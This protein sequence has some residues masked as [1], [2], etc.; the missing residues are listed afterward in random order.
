MRC[1]TQQHPFYGGID[2]HARTMFLC[3]LHRD[4]AMLVHRHRPAGPEPLLKAIAPS[5]EAVVVCV[6]CLF[7]WDWLVDLCARE[8]LPCVLGH[9][10]SMQAIHGGNATHDQ[11]DAQHMAVRR[12]GG[13]LLQASGSP[14]ARRATRA[15]RQRR[16]PLTRTRAAV[17]APIQQTHR[18]DTLPAS[19]QKRASK[20]HRGGGAARCPAPAVPTRVAVDLA[21]RACAD[22][23]R[24][25]GAL[26]S[27]QTA[28]QHDA[29]TVSRLP[30]GPGIGHIVHV[31]WLSER[32]EST[33][34][35]RLQDGVASGRLGT[36]AQA[37]AG[38]R[39]GTPGAQSGHA[40][41]TWAC[42]AAVGLCL[43]THPAGHKSLARVEKTPGQGKAWTVV[44]QTRAR[45][46]SARRR[47]ATVCE[48]PKV[49]NASERG[50]G[51]PHA[52]RDAPGLSLAS[53]ALMLALPRQNTLPEENNVRPNTAEKQVENPRLGSVCLLTTGVL[54][55][56]RPCSWLTRSPPGTTL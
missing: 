41:R 16:G 33:R 19:G 4:G 38:Q 31:V 53:G 7:T 14:A 40:Y 2:V 43:R 56:V 48:R 28:Q 46:V 36:C 54:I 17:R 5:R 18:L 47:R 8:G 45:A 20:A 24:R 34:V 13:R 39:E 26:T 21:L 35:P 9:A 51:E 15:L 50:A 3:I 32:Q 1:D 27:V 11:R 6:A 44:A 49:L 30:A 25:D 22:P 42:S 12:R 29:P 52:S 37:S 55:K 10:R 23:L